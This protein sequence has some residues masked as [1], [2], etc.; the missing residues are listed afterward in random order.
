MFQILFTNFF[1]FKK[2]NAYEL[3]IHDTIII[4]H[5]KT[6]EYKALGW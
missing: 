5:T 4:L 6:S 3:S 1:Y 2:Y